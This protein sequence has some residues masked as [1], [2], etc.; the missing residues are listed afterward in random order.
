MLFTEDILGEGAVNVTENIH[1]SDVQKEI[2]EVNKGT[3]LC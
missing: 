1:V 3:F 2:F